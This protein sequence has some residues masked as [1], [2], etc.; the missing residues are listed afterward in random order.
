MVVKIKEKKEQLEI[1]YLR[2]SFC[3]I[4]LDDVNL[5]F[6]RSNYDSDVKNMITFKIISKT[7]L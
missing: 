6:D 7:H 1:R 4:S 2:D 5:N 3:H